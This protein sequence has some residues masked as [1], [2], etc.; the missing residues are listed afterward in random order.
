MEESI[1]VS[2]LNAQPATAEDHNDEDSNTDDIVSMIKEYLVIDNTR[3]ALRAKAKELRTPMLQNKEA[4]IKYMA[5]H[6]IFRIPTQRNGEEYLELL[7][8]TKTKKPTKVEM[9]Q[10]LQELIRTGTIMDKSAA[11]I[12]E[13]ICKPVQA[14]PSY[15]LY[16]RRKRSRV[17][18]TVAGGVQNVREW[19][20]EKNDPM[21]N[22][23]QRK[24]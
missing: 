1:N 16:R 18:F 14:E 12:M 15:E 2:E 23:E 10:N 24:T 7:Q 20:S 8:K 5:D 11:E 19:L 9:A 21:S 17:V 22:K 3:I 13:C 4:I 6:T